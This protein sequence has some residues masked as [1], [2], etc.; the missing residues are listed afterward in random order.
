M[1][2]FVECKNCKMT[3]QQDEDEPRAKMDSFKLLRAYKHENNGTY[4]C[5]ICKGTAYKSILI[6]D[7]EGG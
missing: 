4:E 7:G 3:A 5:D 1:I 2:R 6:E